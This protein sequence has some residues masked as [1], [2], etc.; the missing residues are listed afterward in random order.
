MRT[1]PYLIGLAVIASLGVF[2]ASAAPGNCDRCFAVVSPDGETLAERG[3]VSSSRRNTGAYLI[4]FRRSTRSCAINAT[5]RDGL[6]LYDRVPSSPR[7]L[8]VFVMNQS[9]TFA[10]DREVSVA[11]TCA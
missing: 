9:A 4:E 5:A 2:E 10:I 6:A 3:V 1:L 8:F 11:V 7:S